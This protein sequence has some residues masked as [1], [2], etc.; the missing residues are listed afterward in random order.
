MNEDHQHPLWQSPSGTIAGWNDK[1]NGVKWATGIKYA[2][3]KRFEAPI[4]QPP[5]DELIDA[6]NWAPACPQPVDPFT[7]QFL[8][9]EFRKLEFDEHC[10]R[11]SVTVP[12]DTNADE[13]LPVMVWIHGGSY[14][15]GAGDHAM[16]NPAT[17]AREQ[18]VIVVNVT[19]RLGLFGY[20]GSE[21]TTPANLGLLDQIEALRWV[22]Q[23]ISSFGGDPENVTVFGE[24][25]G[26]DAIIHLMISS[27]TEGLFTRAIIQSAPF[28]IIRERKEMTDA[29]LKEVAASSIN[30]SAKEVVTAQSGIAKKAEPFGLIASMPFSVQYGHFPL[31]NEEYI[32]EAWQ[33]AAKHVDVL[34]GSNSRELASFVPLIPDLKKLNGIPILGKPIASLFIKRFTNKIYRI[35]QKEFTDRHAAGGGRG[36][37][38]TFAWGARKNRFKG[39]HATE[40]PLLFEDNNLW[41]QNPLL[42]GKSWEEYKRDGKKLRYI[43]GEFARTGQVQE[44]DIEGL[45]K[46]ERI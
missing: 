42:E 1:E 27:G 23:N 35:G 30:G 19:Y 28:G 40:I 29:L 12:V 18:Q 6:T 8:N 37:N 17:L 25:A 4:P 22:Q 3:S 21:E 10:Q 5:A 26:A 44:T 32:D 34:V 36:F 13:A 33:T 31:P 41:D 43:W 14:E 7:D 45:I 11:L 2:D 46:I 20:L 39:G 9:K 38:Y 24:S 15:T 16:Y